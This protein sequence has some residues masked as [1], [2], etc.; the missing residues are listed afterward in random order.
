[1]KMKARIKHSC[2]YEA[3]IDLYTRDGKAEGFPQ[4]SMTLLSADENPAVVVGE[5]V[6]EALNNYTHLKSLFARME[7]AY[8]GGHFNTMEDMLLNEMRSRHP[9]GHTG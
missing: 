1:M 8:V 2:G 9:A 7:A 6:V 3:R 5:A 4:A